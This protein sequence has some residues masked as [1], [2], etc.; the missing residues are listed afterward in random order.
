MFLFL[1]DS[2]GKD[3]FSSSQFK[4]LGYA[5]PF[6]LDYDQNGIGHMDYQ[7]IF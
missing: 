1:K 4:I 7:K 5:I 3:Y 2:E 6:W